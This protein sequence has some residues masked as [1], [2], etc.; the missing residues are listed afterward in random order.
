MVVLQLSGGV[1]SRAGS[2][3]FVHEDIYDEFVTKATALAASKKLGNP[4]Q[5]G[6][7]QGPQVDAEQFKKILGYIEHGKNEGATLCC[8]GKRKGTAG[9]YIEPTVFS[10]VEVSSA[11]SL[12]PQVQ[13]LREPGPG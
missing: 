4:L 2:R 10:D 6:C 12:A 11:L 5:E 8:G 3:T 7:E 9:Y 13:D 1:S